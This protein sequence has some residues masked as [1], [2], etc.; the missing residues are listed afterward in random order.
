MNKFLRL[1]A[2]VVIGLLV[3][4][5]LEMTVLFQQ[6]GM[7]VWES[8]VVFVLT[9]R[10]ATVAGLDPLSV[11]VIPMPGLRTNMAGMIRHHSNSALHWMVSLLMGLVVTVVIWQSILAP[12]YGV[13]V[14]LGTLLGMFVI[15][16]AT[17]VVFVIVTIGSWYLLKKY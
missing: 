2:S 3:S 15:V 6:A 7:F 8:A 12:A 1:S 14:Q 13:Q 10:L 17:F 4:L 16:P 9:A 5:V 11:L